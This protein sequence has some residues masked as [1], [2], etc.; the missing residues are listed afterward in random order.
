MVYYYNVPS[1]LVGFFE[2]KYKLMRIGDAFN[3]DLPITLL[4]SYEQCFSYS[5]ISILD[6]IEIGYKKKFFKKVIFLSSYGVYGKNLGVDPVSEDTICEPQD[7][8]SVL[9]Y[10]TEVALRY[11][12]FKYEVPTYVLRLFTVYS[13]FQPLSYIVPWIVNSIMHDKVLMIG[14]IEKVRDYI[15]VSDMANLIHIIANRKEEEVFNIVNVGTGK[16]TS[17][18]ELIEITESIVGKKARVVFDATRIR[19]EFDPDYAVADISKAKKMFNWK[20][21]VDLERGITYMYHW[22]MGR[23]SVNV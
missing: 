11:L 22:L 21:K 19:E 10:S 16:P 2:K 4:F 14:D 3:R 18:R 1:W 15:Y 8:H 5:S 23:G 6:S 17:V 20:P 12:A 7:A 13:P 9:F